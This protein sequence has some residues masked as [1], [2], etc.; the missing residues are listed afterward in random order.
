MTPVVAIAIGEPTNGD[1]AQEHRLPRLG[2]P[3]GAGHSRH[4]GVLRWV[5]AAV[6]RLSPVGG[7]AAARVGRRCLSA[8]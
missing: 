3:Y 7:M 1:G 6:P 4:G 2:S 5:R 8:S